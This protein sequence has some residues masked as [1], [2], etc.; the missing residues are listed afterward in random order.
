LQAI[1]EQVAGKP[2]VAPVWQAGDEGKEGNSFEL[3][4]KVRTKKKRLL[5]G[6]TVC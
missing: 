6:A 3:Q 1:T 2:N 4:R 5:K